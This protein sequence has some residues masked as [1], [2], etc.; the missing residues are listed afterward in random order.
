VLVKVR[1]I[2]Y[3]SQGS[4][5]RFTILLPFVLSYHVP[6]VFIIHCSYYHPILFRLGS[7]FII[8]DLFRAPSK[9]KKKRTKKKKKVKKREKKKCYC[10]V[11][12]VVSV[13]LKIKKKI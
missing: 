12:F 4:K 7:L 10:I 2:W 1:I 3:Q 8:L 5:I 13:S 6:F 11:T 9:K